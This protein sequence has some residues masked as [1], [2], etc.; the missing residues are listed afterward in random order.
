[1]TKLTEERF[2]KEANERLERY[3]R[4]VRLALRGCRS[5]SADEVERDIREHV[6]SELTAEHGTVS[7]DD[8]NAVFQRLGSPSQWVPQE[9]IPAWR[10]FVLRLRTGPE[11]WRLAYL[12]FA[13]LVVGGLLP[14]IFWVLIP[15]SYLAARASLA[16]ARARNEEL[17]AQKWFIYPPLVVVNAFLLLAVLVGPVI[18]FEMA[19][20]VLYENLNV[21]AALHPPDFTDPASDRGKFVTA[22]MVEALAVWWIVVGIILAIWPRL[23]QIAIAGRNGDGFG[24]K[25]AKALIYTGLAVAILWEIIVVTLFWH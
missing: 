15:A 12:A 4:Q 22:L 2:T 19:G 20:Q 11:D 24:R 16:A 8:L 6:D 18:F 10:R 3:L 1:M 13:L 7:V 21:R 23:A 17:G 9:E 14:G 5:V 25:L